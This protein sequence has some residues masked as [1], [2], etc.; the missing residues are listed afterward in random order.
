MNEPTMPTAQV[1]T[2]DIYRRF[3]LA[4]LNVET[5]KKDQQANIKENFSYKYADINQILA[6]LKPILAAQD[7]VV[8]QPIAFVDGHMMVSTTLIC[9][10]TGQSV[11]FPGPACPTKADPQALGG[12]IT[13]FRRY[14]LVS[15]FSLEAADDDAGAAG[16]QARDPENRTAAETEIR[17]AVGKMGRPERHFFLHDFVDHFG[18]GLTELG[19]SKHGDA[20]TYFKGWTY[21][22]VRGEEAEAAKAAE[23]VE[24]QSA[25]QHT[26][27]GTEQ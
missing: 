25:N 8:S 24:Q 6:M 5:V 14:G 4:A 1:D 15:L 12:A 13:Y 17:K 19:E 23:I 18:S 9:T 21:D 16:R 20:L 10:R 22:P 11:N 3:A 27:E 7:L 26:P 2:A